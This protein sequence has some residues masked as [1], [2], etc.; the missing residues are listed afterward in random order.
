MH[1]SGLLPAKLDTRIFISI[2][3]SLIKVKPVFNRRYAFSSPEGSFPYGVFTRNMNP[4]VKWN[5]LAVGVPQKIQ[6]LLLFR[7]LA[8]DLWSRGQVS[9]CVNAHSGIVSSMGRTIRN[10]LQ[11]T[12]T[13]GQFPVLRNFATF[14]FWKILL[15]LV[16]R[17]IQIS[18]IMNDAIWL[19]ARDID[20]LVLV[21]VFV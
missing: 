4:L 16:C 10:D 6:P 3:Y 9:S 19:L 11:T 12:I 7:F 17:R 8:S 20:F 2:E 18:M 21:F 13:H 14:L 5:A 1:F 15:R